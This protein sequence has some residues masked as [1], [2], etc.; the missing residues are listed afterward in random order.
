[1]S[2]SSTI[3]FSDT[4]PVAPD[5]SAVLEAQQ[6]LFQQA[7]DNKLNTEASTPQG[8]LMTSLAAIVQDK[9][10]KLL[11]LANM[12]NPATSEGM[13]QDALAKIYFIDR[14]G[15]QATT[16]QVTCTGAAGTVIPG[17][18]TSNDPARVAAE[19]GTQYYCT[20]GGTIPPSGS[21]V[22][23]FECV[24]P[25]AVELD[26]HDIVS[27][28]QAIPGW[29]TADNESVGVTGNSV[30]S[31]QAFETRRYASVAMNSRSM[32]A[33]VYSR[34]ANLD[35]VLDILVRQNRGDNPKEDN[36]VSLKPHSI[37]VCVLGGADAEIAEAIY[38]TVSGGC[39]YNGETSVEY[40]DPTTGAVETIL[41][42]RPE[43]FEFAIEVTIRITSSAPS[44]VEELIKSNVYADFY[45]EPYINSG[46]NTVHTNESMRVKIGEEVLASRFFCP[47]IS[48]GANGLLSVTIG[49]YGGSSLGTSV[50]LTNK[51][52]PSLSEDHIVV[53]VED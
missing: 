14:H 18:D 38:N 42:Q 1:M 50:Q 37:Y 27:I 45:G 48:A 9:N 51:Q 44:N 31:Q 24:Q 34:V 52:Y 33:S 6:N 30:E 49:K 20:T 47:V 16:V 41:F 36:G 13:F 46:T 23:P 15:A 35:G 4:G 19:D 17:A 25:G 5:T 11:Y 29:D 10:S 32:L 21:I 8:Q 2:E 53:K 22:L 7:F 28:V 12:F 3:T 43:E 40:T 39:D 26:A